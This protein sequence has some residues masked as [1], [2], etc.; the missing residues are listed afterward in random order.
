MDVKL[1]AMRSSSISHDAQSLRYYE[2]TLGGMFG[3]P[4]CLQKKHFI[5]H[6]GTPLPVG[7]KCFG[8]RRDELS[9]WGDTL[10]TKGL[11]RKSYAS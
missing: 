3:T 4:T 5:M 11:I 7:Q 1:P 9:A 10:V 6:K 8:K 2:V